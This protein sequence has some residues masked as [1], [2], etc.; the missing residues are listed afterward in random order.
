MKGIDVGNIYPRR[1]LRTGVVKADHSPAKDFA[2]SD[3]ALHKICRMHDIPNP[4]L[5]WWAKKAAGR[6]VKQTPLPRAKAGTATSF[7]IAAGET[8][9]EPD[10]IA[11]VRENARM[12]ASTVTHQ[13]RPSP[14]P[15]VELTARRLGKAKTPGL[16]GLVSVK[17]AGLIQ[18]QLAPASID[19]F[20]LALNH[21]AAAAAVIGIELLRGETAAVFWCD[22]E[23]IGFSVT[24]AVRREKHIPTDKER[25]DQ[26]AWQRKQ[27]RRWQRDSWNDIGGSFMGPQIPDWD[28]HPTGQLAFEFEQFYFL[29]VCPRRSFRDGKTQRLETMAADIAV[30]AAVLAAAKK[31]DRLHRE[32]DARIRDQAR[33]RR[34]QTLRD[35]YTEERREAALDKV[36]QDIAALERLRRLVASLQAEL[37]AAADGRVATFLA[38]AE[39]RLDAR[40]AALSAGGLSAQFTNQRLFGSDDDHGF[41][42]PH[43]Y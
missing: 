18:C 3:V 12:L 36:L 24:E 41:R 40:E 23:T 11:A 2:L 15:I 42:V 29:S 17:G 5:G 9:H 4:P 21:I 25:A 38:F 37:T 1:I 14:H 43:C 32:E 33:L 20:E 39:R 35:T 31:Q 30:G 13:G 16:A 34:E 7:T 6:K 19:R 27:A 26:E 22:G 28:H 10:A 8:R